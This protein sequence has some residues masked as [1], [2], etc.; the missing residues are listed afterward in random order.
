MGSQSRIKTTQAK[1]VERKKKAND[2]SSRICFRVLAMRTVLT[3]RDWQAVLI[4]LFNS[5]FAISSNTHVLQ[6]QSSQTSNG[7]AILEPASGALLG[8]FYGAGSL[9]DTSKKLGRT[10]PV[11]LTYYAW[12]TDWT[13]SVPKADLAAGRIP[14][15]NWE[16]HHID[17][18]KII[19]GSLDVTIKAREN[20][21]QTPGDQA[22][23]F[24][25]SHRTARQE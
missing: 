17:F 8:A 5:L 25:S 18:H 23:S 2:R 14:L 10:L 12:D 4:F 21:P 16:P 22:F 3:K 19:D 15:V 24:S 13:G 9:D 6:A 20:E 1:C 11:H 7:S